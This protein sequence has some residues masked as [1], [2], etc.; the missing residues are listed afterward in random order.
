[1]ASSI[2]IRIMF[3]GQASYTQIGGV[4]IGKEKLGLLSVLNIGVFLR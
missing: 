2:V 1:M 3:G 4:F